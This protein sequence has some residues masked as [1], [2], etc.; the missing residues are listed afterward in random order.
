L[1]FYRKEVDNE[2]KKQTNKR[3][4]RGS[5]ERNFVSYLL[6]HGKFKDVQKP[7][8][9]PCLT[10]LLSAH[11]LVDWMQISNELGEKAINTAGYPN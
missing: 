10:N 3:V 6:S 1:K 7:V 5:E 11:F 9:L 8:S 4:C 2:T